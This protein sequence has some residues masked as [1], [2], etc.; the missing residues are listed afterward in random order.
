MGPK[1]TWGGRRAE[2]AGRGRGSRRLGR[3]IR[4]E[5]DITK[6]SIFTWLHSRVVQ[7]NSKSQN[8]SLCMSQERE[9][10]KENES[11]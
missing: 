7:K 6:N 1:K 10:L 4:T 2:T 5:A 3:E 11:E 9:R 8:Y